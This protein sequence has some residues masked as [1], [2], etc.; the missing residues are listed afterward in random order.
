MQINKSIVIVAGE[1]SGDLHAS[2]LIRELL[3]LEPGIKLEGMGGE[4]MRRAGVDILVDNKELA[5]MGLVEVLAKYTIIKSALEKL[6][7]H[8]QRSKPDLLI[9][10][11]YQEFNQKLAAYAK[12]IGIKVLFY[13]SPQVWAWRPKR[14]YKMAK[15]VDQMAV[16]FP[17][18][19]D[20]YKDA[21]VPVEFTGNPLVDEVIRDKTPEQA[22]EALAIDQSITVGLFPGSRQGEIQRLL[23]IQLEAAKILLKY[24]PELQFVLPLADSLDEIVLDPFLSE[25]GALN[26]RIIRDKV[27]DV[28][29]ACNAIITASGT[30]TLEIALMGVPMAIIYRVAPVTY[31]I[32][33]HMVNADRIGLPN[34]VAGKDIVREFLQGKAKPKLI[35]A[36]IQHILTDQEYQQTIKNELSL[37]RQQLGDKS[38]SVHIAQL[39]YDMLHGKKP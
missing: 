38:G 19:V 11:D 26:V 3:K 22:R 35:A 10:V 33:K 6:K 27:Y 8:I 15:I 20:L 9:L 12:S 1:A 17:F 24:N 13:I 18:E 29:Q 14:V 2:K 31:F 23:P 25:L 37:I 28:M 21:N 39:A 34:I 32:L 16:I 7:Q 36:E 5:V 4:N 30:A